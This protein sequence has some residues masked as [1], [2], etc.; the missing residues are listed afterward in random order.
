M[1]EPEDEDDE[2]GKAYQKAMVGEVSPSK[3]I[4]NNELSMIDEKPPARFVVVKKLSRDKQSKTSQ[5]VK[6]FKIVTRN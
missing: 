1:L 4:K 3:S 5:N 6:T 2:S